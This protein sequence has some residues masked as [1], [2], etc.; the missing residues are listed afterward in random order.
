MLL[1]VEDACFSIVK[2]LNS[3]VILFFDV[4]CLWVSVHHFHD[5]W[6]KNAGT[7]ETWKK[8]ER[9]TC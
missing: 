5:R 9:R 8:E 4:V 3:F 1:T 7:K 2:I 6:I